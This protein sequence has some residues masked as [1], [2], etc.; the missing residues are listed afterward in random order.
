[1]IIEHPRIAGFSLVAPRLGQLGETQTH[2]RLSVEVPAGQTVNVDVVL[3]RPGEQRVSI[4]GIGQSELGV[5]VLTT[6]IP[7]AVRDALKH[8]AALQ[9]TLADRQQAL[10]A[11]ENDRN[12]VIA[13]QTRIRENLKVVSTDN[14]LRM[15]YLTALGESEDRI[16]MLDQSI[17][18]AR[19]AVT[20]ARDELEQFISTL[21]L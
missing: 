4:V 3:E 17:G 10:T 14:E 20:V 1:M 12:T 8:V 15:R 18:V 19:E 2:H 9:R 21:S 13:D 16:A 11:L 7:E 6:E 5:L